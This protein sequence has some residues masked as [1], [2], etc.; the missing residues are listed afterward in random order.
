METRETSQVMS[1]TTGSILMQSNES[2]MRRGA[3]L[4]I[5]VEISSEDDMIDGSPRYFTTTY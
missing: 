5:K 4:I 3:Q 1:T 2:R